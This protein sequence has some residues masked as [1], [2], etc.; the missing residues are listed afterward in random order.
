MDSEALRKCLCCKE[1]FV[2]DA[3]HR[4]DQKYCRKRACR[5]ASKAASQRAWLSRP[6]NRDYFCGP[7]HVERVRQWRAEHPGYWKEVQEK[8][9]LQDS[10]DHVQP[11]DLKRD[12]LGLDCVTR[13]DR[14]P[15]WRRESP[16]VIGLIAQLTGSTLQE[17]I[18][19]TT[20]R[21]FEKGQ[22]VIGHST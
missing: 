17:T 5:R 11:A 7:E 1:V 21:L 10:M 4:A 9:A 20:H 12:D 18:A 15:L 13:F 19:Q 6:E 8:G 2:V 14:Q 16:L 22:A 3:R